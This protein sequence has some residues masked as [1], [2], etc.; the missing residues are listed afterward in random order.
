MAISIIMNNINW[1]CSF[2]WATVNTFQQHQWRGHWLS[3]FTWINFCLF[4]WITFWCHGTPTRT[5]IFQ[6]EVN[7]ANGTPTLD[8]CT[9]WQYIVTMH[10]LIISKL[11]YKCRITASMSTTG[12]HYTTKLLVVI[13][14]DFL[15]RKH[16]HYTMSQFVLHLNLNYYVRWL[17]PSSDSHPTRGPTFVLWHTLHN[18]FLDLFPKSAHHVTYNRKSH[19]KSG[20]TIQLT[21][22][23]WKLVLPATYNRLLYSVCLA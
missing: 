5:L 15:Q 9:R 7:Y 1:K 22:V 11:V 12:T 8:V 2:E 23:T 17:A 14:P 19:R 3:F 18:N 4:V 16:V 6:G 13:S 21:I 10:R 20:D